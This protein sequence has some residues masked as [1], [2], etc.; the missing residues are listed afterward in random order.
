MATANPNRLYPSRLGPSPA[1]QSAL[2]QTTRF[3]V[4]SARRVPSPISTEPSAALA[5]ARALTLTRR[6][7]PSCLGYLAHRCGVRGSAPP[8]SFSFP[9]PSV[10][11]RG[12]SSPSP[13][14][15]A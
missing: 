1:K 7:L 3:H 14:V 8:H 2:G 12:G 13:A 5:E 6:A 15:D 9:L 4:R 11:A 10:S